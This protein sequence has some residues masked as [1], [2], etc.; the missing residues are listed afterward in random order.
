MRAWIVAWAVAAGAMTALAQPE[1]PAGTE[2]VDPLVLGDPA[3]KLRIAEWIKGRPVDSFVP[4]RVYAIEFWATWC[5]P[6]IAGIPHLSEVQER[7]REH[8]DVVSVTAE[9]PNNS[10]ETVRAFVEAQGEAMD[11][12]VAFD[13]ARRT[14]A[15]YME[16]A[17]QSGIPCAFIVDKQGRLAWVGHPADPAFEQTIEL[18]VRD[19]FDL[20]GAKKAEAERAARATRLARMQ[21]DLHKAWE[22][23]DHE[24]ALALA[25]EIVAAD[26]A[27][28]AQ[29]AWWKFEALLVGLDRPEEAYAY[30]ARLSDDA[31][32]DNADML[33]RFAYGI[34]DSLGVE[35]PDTDLA[36]ELARRAVELTGN[37][38]YRSLAGLAMVHIRRKEFDEAIAVQQRAVDIAPSPAVRQHLQNDLDFYRMDKEFEE[39]G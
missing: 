38:D 31:Y 19:E 39:G 35:D 5:G 16:A 28:M 23:G 11:Y 4:G 17:E 1:P 32:A 9:D 33:L 36:L 25:D 29:W 7:F 21:A 2:T 30:V 26:P 14:W 6:C 3:P 37:Q 27:G 22:S 20:E 10:L 18:I 34:A 13:D 8:A 15:A 12:R 24:R